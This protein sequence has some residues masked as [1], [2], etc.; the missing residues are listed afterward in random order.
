MLYVPRS[1]KIKQ[2]AR[3]KLH[4][5]LNRICC[6][7]KDGI[8]FFAS[9]QINECPVRN[10]LQLHA[11]GRYCMSVIIVWLFKKKKKK[12]VQQHKAAS[13]ALTFPQ[14]STFE[15]HCHSPEG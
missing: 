2:T 3:A 10:Q 13:N 7:S 12:T 5:M 1:M 14:V 4:E 6:Q 15:L 9:L 11:Y 8:A